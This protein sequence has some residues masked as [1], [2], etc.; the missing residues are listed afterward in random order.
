MF[1]SKF[2]RVQRS[3]FPESL[4]KMGFTLLCLADTLAVVVTAVVALASLGLWL[5]HVR[6][7][8]CIQATAGTSEEPA[9]LLGPTLASKRAEKEKPTPVSKPEQTEAQCRD[10][11]PNP[12]EA[13]S[14]SSFSV[15]G[16]D[17]PPPEPYVFVLPQGDKFHSRE[18]HARGKSPPVRISLSQARN[19]GYHPCD[20]CCGPEWKE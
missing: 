1:V 2:L 15:V 8:T 19:L 17:P 13:S 4:E 3:E 20:H 9:E 7:N 5:W 16:S 6:G 18:S 11:D 12:R 10:P 14:D